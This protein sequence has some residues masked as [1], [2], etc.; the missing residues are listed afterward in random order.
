MYIFPLRKGRKNRKASWVGVITLTFP[1]GAMV[2]LTV[3]LG[4][5]VRVGRGQKVLGGAR[6]TI[7][8]LVLG[9]QVGWGRESSRLT[10]ERTVIGGYFLSY[11]APGNHGIFFTEREKMGNNID[12]CPDID[13]PT[14]WTTG[15]ENPPETCHRIRN[16]GIFDEH[17]DSIIPKC[18]KCHRHIYSG[19][20]FS[21]LIL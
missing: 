20:N 8:T 5:W 18:I 7:L 9:P 16:K 19:T 13:S 11:C 12:Q 17:S 6:H 10:A 4:Q 2:N 1:L 21:C 15:S 14:G 3:L